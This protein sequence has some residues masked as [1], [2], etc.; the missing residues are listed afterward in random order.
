MAFEGDAAKVGMA[1]DLA[2]ACAAVTDADRCVAAIKLL[3]CGH[4][5]AKKRGF[6][7]EQLFE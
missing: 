1:R 7:F 5:T 3:E 2:T 4:N 6:S